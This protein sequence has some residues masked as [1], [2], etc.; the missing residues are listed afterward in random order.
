MEASLSFGRRLIV[1]GAIGMAALTNPP[2]LAQV[3]ISAGLRIEVPSRTMKDLRDQDVVKQRFD[4]SCG[5][6]A[7][8][9]LLRYGFGE[10]ISEDQILV[11]LFNL[12][13]EA[14]KAARRRT[15]FSLLDLQRVA[16]SRGH[17]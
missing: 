17:R 9:T 2:C 5:A 3:G 4:F 1:G 8:A 6:A 12:P 14:E 7:F 10:N 13:S 11:E 15:G 16:Q